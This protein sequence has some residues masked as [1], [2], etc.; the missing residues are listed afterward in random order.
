M[1]G[2]PK[3]PPS[4]RLAPIWRRHP[5]ATTLLLAVAGLFIYERV[6]GKLPVGDDYT[7]YHNQVF[8]V[9]NVVD[10]DTFDI[11]V[12]DS[13]YP[14]TRIR[15]WGVDTP[16]VAGKRSE[17]MYFGREASAFAK[18]RLMGRSVRVVLS[19]TR[20]RGLY[21]RLLAYVYL[22]PSGQMFNELLIENG[23]AYAD[24]RFA[25]PY[26]RQFMAQEKRAQRAA[27]GLWANVT[28]EQKPPWRQRMENRRD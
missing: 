28:Q 3:L 19:P 6:L 14:T 1:W 11:D 5:A 18:R 8:E 25:H 4:I 26:K 9:V 17:G 24:W 16:E 23:Y 2:R 10:G 13:Q 12:P 7:R 21:G 15:L 22:Q 20:T 27:A